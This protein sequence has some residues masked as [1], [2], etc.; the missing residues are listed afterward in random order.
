M[1][2][3][4]EWRFNIRNSLGG[5]IISLIVTIGVLLFIVRGDIDKLF[6]GLLSANMKLVFLAISIYFL[7]VA[8]WA[9]RWKVALGAIDQDISFGKIYLICQGGKFVTNVTPIM[10]AGGDPFRAYFAKKI[11]GI[12]YNEGL[13]TLL[14]ETAVSI[15]VFLSFLTVGLFFWLYMQGLVLIPIIVLILMISGVI[16]F[17]PFVNWL[18]ARETA[19]EHLASFLNWINEKLGRE[20]NSKKIIKSL[21]KLYKSTN[22]VMKHKKSGFFMII[23]SILLYTFTIVRFYV[24]FL[25]LGLEVSWY[26]PFL[27]STLPFIFGLIPFSPGGLIYVEGGMTGLLILMGIERSAATSA[28]IIERGISYLISTIAGGIA[29]SYLGLKIWKNNS[30]EEED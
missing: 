17:L 2:S 13:G 3:P 8:L 10:K 24:I 29:A 30:D 20:S 26:V 28:V 15:P 27:G 22:F 9:G 14:A 23:L 4:K 25:A 1:N 21:K 7:E 6:H 12:P 16:F 19:L 18:I 5:V 11:H